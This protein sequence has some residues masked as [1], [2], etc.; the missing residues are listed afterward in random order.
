M[1]TR[2]LSDSQ[3]YQR[4]ILGAKDRHHCYSAAHGV[5]EVDVPAAGSNE[6]QTQQAATARR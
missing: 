2:R 1:L 5:A 6:N 3:L 4:T